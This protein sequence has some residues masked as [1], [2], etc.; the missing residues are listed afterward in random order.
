MP[1]Q[2]HPTTRFTL[3]K[4]SI[5]FAYDVGCYEDFTVEATS[6][7]EA[8]KIAQK[9]LKEGRFKNVNGEPDWNAITNYRVFPLDHTFPDGDSMEQIIREADE[10][11]GMTA[12]QMLQNSVSKAV[13]ILSEAKTK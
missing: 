8:L 1:K 10:R 6:E 3:K 7:M 13:S 12:E 2:K 4:F 11:I 5:A 9:A